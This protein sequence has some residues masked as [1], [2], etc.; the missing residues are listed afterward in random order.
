MK[1]RMSKLSV[2]IILVLAATGFAFA[3]KGH[4]KLLGTWNF[5]APDAPYEYQV[6]N[7]II[8]KDKGNYKGEIIFSEYYKIQTTNLK[9][10]GDTLSFKAFVEGD[11]VYFKGTVKKN[12]LTGKASYSEGSLP[13]IAEKV[14]K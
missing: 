3:Q 9:V 7:I 4:T 12:K 2:I 11:V 5:K 10:T 14:K 1:K 13:V 8:T 6:G